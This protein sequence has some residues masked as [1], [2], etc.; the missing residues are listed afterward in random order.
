MEHGWLQS[1]LRTGL[2]EALPL[3]EDAYMGLGSAELRRRML[4]TLERALAL[5][6]GAAWHERGALPD[7]RHHDGF[8]QGHPVAL[9]GE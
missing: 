6:R 8:V 2:R 9:T 1:V 4:A 5:L 3:R 7:V